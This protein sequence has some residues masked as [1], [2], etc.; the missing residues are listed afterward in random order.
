MPLKTYDVLKGRVLARRLS[1]W[2]SPHY[3]VRIL[4]EMGTNYRAAI[5]VKSQ[6]LIRQF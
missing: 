5:N 2:S 1:S 3:Q 6:L 4:D